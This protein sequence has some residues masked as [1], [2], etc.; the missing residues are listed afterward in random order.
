MARSLSR[1]RRT[2]AA[3]ERFVTMVLHVALAASDY[4]CGL[5]SPRSPE[6][7]QACPPPSAALDQLS[8]PLPCPVPRRYLEK[9]VGLYLD[10]SPRGAWHAP[11]RCGL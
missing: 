1:R 2:L 6:S 5:L 9:P 11:W 4:D 7:R 3:E 8:L 10:L